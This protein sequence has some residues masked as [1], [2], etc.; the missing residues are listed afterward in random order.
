VKVRGTAAFD[1]F[2]IFSGAPAL[3]ENTTLCVTAPNIHVTDPPRA[4]TTRDGLNAFAGLVST[5][6]SLGRGATSTREIAV[7]FIPLAVS[8]AV[9]VL[10]PAPVAL[11]TPPLFTIATLGALD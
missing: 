2:T 10:D 4:S 6:A 8:D 7:R 5:V 11:T 1:V 9:M 3:G